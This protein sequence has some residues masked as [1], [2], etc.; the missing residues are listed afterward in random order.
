MKYQNRCITEKKN[1]ILQCFLIFNNQ[2][3]IMVS[4]LFQV[5]FH[6]NLE[7]LFAKLHLFII[8]FYDFF[9]LIYLIL[10]KI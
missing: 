7:K 10:K 9:F 4:L 2:Y 3:Y 6:I 5:Q 1:K 8:K